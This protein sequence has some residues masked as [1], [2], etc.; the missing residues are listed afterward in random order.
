VGIYDPWKSAWLS[1]LADEKMLN[2]DGFV[3]IIVNEEHAFLPAEVRLA[4]FLHSMFGHWLQGKMH[5][6]RDRWMKA[7]KDFFPLLL[8]SRL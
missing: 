7:R 2:A 1:T 5:G 4:L 8:A 3:A 6:W